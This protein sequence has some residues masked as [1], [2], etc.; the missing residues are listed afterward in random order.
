MLMDCVIMER[1]GAAI[2]GVARGP[3]GD[4]LFGFKMAIRFRQVK[5]ESDDALLIEVL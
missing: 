2:S 1:L 3:S 5:L 4:W